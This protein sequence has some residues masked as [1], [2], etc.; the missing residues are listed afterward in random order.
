MTRIQS[1]G[2]LFYLFLFSQAVCAQADTEAFHIENELSGVVLDHTIT[3]TG[4]EFAD[5]LTRFRQSLYPGADYNL[6]V[7]ERPSARWGS[8]LWITS[9]R[10]IVF[11][12]FIHP[13]RANIKKTAR[14]AISSVD[15]TLRKTRLRQLFS[16]TFDLERD[17]F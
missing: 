7:R 9:N 11:K 13:S 10:K 3:R 6:V 12:T 5:H 14:Q 1:T 2:I 8:L 15:E 17:E 4:H 16:D